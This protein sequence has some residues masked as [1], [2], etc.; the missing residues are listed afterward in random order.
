[1]PLRELSPPQDEPVS[2]EEAKLH[3]R[4][5]AS[6]EDDLITGLIS[7]A[8]EW[9]EQRCGVAF[10]QR[11]LLYTLP[12]FPAD[13]YIE[14]PMAVAGDFS[15]TSFMYW[16]ADGVYGAVAAISYTDDV[17][18]PIRLGLKPGSQW[19][20]TYGR[21]DSVQITYQAGWANAADVPARAKQAIKL[22]VGH[23][24]A[25]REDVV[26]GTIATQVQTAAEALLE[27]LWPG[28]LV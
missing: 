25:N 22:L 26:T 18:Q 14:L 24:Y 16:N 12:K 21:S 15:L 2:L 19:P 6:D 9:C 23:W 13:D 27:S 3:L 20:S 11:T 5:D 4:V 1:M 17:A 10:M 7:A 28:N 8:R